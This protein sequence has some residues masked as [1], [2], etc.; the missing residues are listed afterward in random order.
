MVIG[1]KASLGYDGKFLCVFT[2]AGE[3]TC[4]TGLYKVSD[5]R[6]WKL[7]C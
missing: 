2:N 6:E 3:W 5:V 7:Q 4:D 1:T